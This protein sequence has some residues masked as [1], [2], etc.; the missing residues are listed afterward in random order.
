MLKLLNI[1]TLLNIEKLTPSQAEEL[2]KLFKDKIGKYTPSITFITYNQKRDFEKRCV[3]NKIYSSYEI[4]VDYKYKY[5]TN[6]YA[7]LIYLTKEKA[8]ENIN[9]I[10]N[11]KKYIIKFSGLHF[12]KVCRQTLNSNTILNDLIM[13]ALENEWKDNPGIYFP[14]KADYWTSKQSKEVELYKQPSKKTI[15]I[16][17]KNKNKKDINDFIK[18]LNIKKEIENYY[19]TLIYLEIKE[20]KRYLNRVKK[21]IKAEVWSKKTN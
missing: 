11:K 14:P 4:K 5:D 15:T 2:K 13:N 16:G 3:E 20:L 17:N 19:P 8:K 7:F 6:K 9:A 12:K 21:N 18:K 10:K 1:K